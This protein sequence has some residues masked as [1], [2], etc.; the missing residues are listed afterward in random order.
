M[1]SRLAS[2]SERLISLTHNIS[3]VLLAVATALVSIQVITRFGIGHAAAWTEIVARGVVVWMVFMVSGAG[4]RYGAM[5]PLEFI[6]DIVPA[7]IK[8]VVMIAVT[9][10]VL[11]FLGVLAWY[12]TMMALRVSGQKIAMLHISMAWF[13][14]AIPVG[15]ALAVPGIL[16]AHFSPRELSKDMHE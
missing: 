5:I 6:R 1:R 15:A 7:P 11:V 10:L 8:R 14:A 4:F 16:L 12:G 9:T 3:A 13:Y 2:A